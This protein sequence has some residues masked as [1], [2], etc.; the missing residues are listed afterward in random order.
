[1]AKKKTKPPAPPK[2]P[3]EK[4]EDSIQKS[5]RFQLAL[6]KRIDRASKDLGTDG[7]SV[8]R[9]VMIEFLP[10]IEERI[11]RIKEGGKP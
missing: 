10:Q 5:I 8:V 11:R 4:E 9:M 1:M 3:V 6:W 2:P 7:S